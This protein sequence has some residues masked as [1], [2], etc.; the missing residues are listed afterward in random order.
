MAFVINNIGLNLL[1]LFLSYA[2]LFCLSLFSTV[3]NAHTELNQWKEKHFFLKGHK[4]VYPIHTC[5]QHCPLVI[6]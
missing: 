6:R 5:I 4:Y 2:I 3:V 1:I